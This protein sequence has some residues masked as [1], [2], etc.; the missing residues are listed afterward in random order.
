MIDDR[1]DMV[2]TCQQSD[3]VVEETVRVLKI[4][5][6]IQPI[7]GNIVEQQSTATSSQT[8]G[9][10]RTQRR[11]SASQ[12][13][14][15]V[16]PGTSSTSREKG[17]DRT[18]RNN[19]SATAIVTGRAKA[20]LTRHNKVVE[21]NEYGRREADATNSRDNAYRDAQSAGLLYLED[22]STRYSEAGNQGWL[23]AHAKVKLSFWTDESPAILE[24]TMREAHRACIP[25]RYA[26][27][28]LEIARYE[29]D[30]AGTL[31]D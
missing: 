27:S 20:S 9:Q 11:G 25:P 7:D 26:E 21:P 10:L 19:R 31:G 13:S 2:D 30:I 22:N 15:R 8:M 14:S 29:Y 6:P 23:P 24:D 28:D 4:P 1:L 17:A 16:P 18:L 3:Q 5:L 12:G